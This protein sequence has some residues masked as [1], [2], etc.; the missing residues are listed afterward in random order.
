MAPRGEETR[1]SGLCQFGTP[2]CQLRP[3]RG[4]FLL[5]DVDRG[6]DH[7]RPVFVGAVWQNLADEPKA[8][9]RFDHSREGN[10][11][12]QHSPRIRKEC[13]VGGQRLEIRERSPEIA[14]INAE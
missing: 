13:A 10:L 6:D 3:L 1:L 7:A 12:L 14:R 4:L 8:A 9:L 5:S 11:F 2:P